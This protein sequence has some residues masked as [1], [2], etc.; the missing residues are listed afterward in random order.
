MS[1]KVQTRTG[2]KEL[3]QEGSSDLTAREKYNI[4][5]DVNANLF[6]FQTRDEDDY[7]S[8]GRGRGGRGGRDQGRGGRGGRDQ[9]PREQRGGRKRDGKLVVD[10]ND[11][12]AL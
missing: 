11:F 9:G 7:E 12:P 8:R 10:D 6:G 4:R 5:P 1:E 3:V 2:T